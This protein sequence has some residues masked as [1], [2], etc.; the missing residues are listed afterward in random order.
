MA[1]GAITLFDRSAETE[2]YGADA[3]GSVA[4]RL[5]GAKADDRTGGLRRA[6]IDGSATAQQ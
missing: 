3:D 1:T 5:A 2:G 6:H 4:S